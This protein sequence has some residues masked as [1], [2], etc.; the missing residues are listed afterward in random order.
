MKIN[1]N[2]IK[3]LLVSWVIFLTLTTACL[4]QYSGGSGTNAAPYEIA[5][6]LDL[7]NLGNTTADYDKHFI[8]IANVNMAGY[9]FSRAVIAADNS[10]DK[11]FLG[12]QFSGIFDGNGYTISNLT[13][14]ATDKDYIGLFGNVINA[15]IFNLGMEAVN[16]NNAGFGRY[17]G[18]LVGYSDHSTISNSF[19]TGIVGGNGYSIGGLVGYIDNGIIN[20]CYATGAVSGS[21]FYVGGL[22][23]YIDYGTVNNSYATAN[24]TSNGSSNGGLVGFN[25][26]GNISTSYASG[27]VNGGGWDVGGL[28]GRNLYGTISMSYALGA[29]S[30]NFPVGGLVGESNGGI[31]IC[32][33]S[34]LVSGLDRV[35]GLVGWNNSGTITACFWDTQTSNRAIGVGDGSTTGVMGKTTGEM[36][37]QSTFI[38]AG[39]DFE[40]IWTID[41]GQYPRLFVQKYSGGNGVSIAP[42]RITTINDL[43][44]LGQRTVD[45]NKCFILT[46]DIDLS[47]YSFVK[48]VIAS[49]TPFSGNFNGNGHTIS[50]LTING[51]DKDGV[52]LFGC[53]ASNA[54]ICYLGLENVNVTGKNN[55]GGLV[56][57]ND[58]STIYASYAKGFVTGSVDHVGGL[59]GSNS[60]GI[61]NDS[62]ASV[63][64]S[65]GGAAA[66]GLAGYNNSGVISNSYATGNVTGNVF[67]AGLVGYN[68]S[69]TITD[70][71]WD[72]QTSG[73]AIGIAGGIKLG[74]IG[75]S[76]N[77]MKKQ[78]TFTEAGWDFVGEQENG[79][80][81]IWYLPW[82]SYPIFALN[83]EVV[84]KSQ[85]G[86]Q[87]YL[88]GTEQE[89]RW[90]TFGDIDTILIEYSTDNGDN[91][92]SI[93]PANIGNTGSYFW[94]VPYEI[95]DQCLIRV[96][97][98]DNPGVNDA[99]DAVFSISP[100]TA[101]LI[102]PNGNESFMTG[103]PVPVIWET[104]GIIENISIEY[105]TDNGTVWHAV[106]P[107]NSGNLGGYQ[108]FAADTVSDEC[109]IRVSDA[110][111]PGV[112]D[113]SDNVFHIV[114]SQPQ[115][116]TLNG[117]EKLISGTIKK[118]KWWTRGS[119][120]EIA[121]EYSI[122][123]GATW[124]EMSPA[125]VGNT[126]SYEWNVPA[127][128][129]DECLVR[130]SDR[131]QPSRYDISDTIFEIAPILLQSNPGGQR[132][133]I[134][135]QYAIKWQA[136]TGII[137]GDVELAYSIDKGNNWIDIITTENNGEYLWNVPAT[138]SNGYLIQVAD[139]ANPDVNDISNVFVVYDCTKT[140]IGD[141][142][143]DCFVDLQDFILMANNWLM[144]GQL[145]L[146]E[147]DL[148]ND[149]QWSM[150]GQWQFGQPQGA[151]GTV[152]GNPDPTAGFTGTN[153]YG[154]NL[155]GDYD[156]AIAD[157]YY[158]T[159]GPIDCSLY[160]NIQLRFRSWLNSDTANYVGHTVEVS[161]DGSQ[162]HQ[163][164]INSEEA[165]TD[166]QWQEMEF[167]IS[168]YA[169]DNA[170]LYIRW[171]YQI[172]DRAYPYAGW[173]I[174]DVQLLGNP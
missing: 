131:Y 33:A 49:D 130:V 114:N 132:M 25:N 14:S 5:T 41:P 129:S 118:I 65:G 113:V 140:L 54:V 12:T 64:V 23:G 48:P 105:S 86:G 70:C 160:Y 80:D 32:Y 134:D 53:T 169:D 27:T 112:Y 174:D 55:V 44:I 135:S 120:S 69:G 110:D 15:S 10:T 165:I 92:S 75:K 17:V 106:D 58:N 166:E 93:S 50:N 9:S 172:I 46:S 78:V 87:F 7:I 102:H 38:T 99:S 144:A 96:S 167:D 13:I 39:W 45:Y 68:F 123:N 127:V 108:W 117:N 56:G 2:S 77:E 124:F 20:D 31:S 145:N 67:V 1:S 63:A 137:T 152:Y 111:H 139:A 28:V 95:S 37:I 76:T 81:D 149:P 97:D 16:I 171:G 91:W 115:L 141:I 19:S 159:A 161:A 119:I 156:T 71:F 11:Y 42:Y 26:Y 162:W 84:L 168:E 104:N 128:D 164:W 155:A 59:V 21:G 3:Y 60:Y 79:A 133:L 22:V 158:L 148:D 101:V 34:G 66:G 85:N 170:M 57:G 126:G 107:E 94:Q 146:I 30:G 83:I 116:L 74:A 40:Y 147:F 173:N 157:P 163:L 154:V 24:I 82:E 143:G 122:N 51:N 151:G 136:D 18:G 100:S 47:G 6:A 52:G 142:N 29:V 153:V 43:I 89:I 125:N 4:G 109:L 90:E 138:S 36:Q 103:I 8:L 88:S 61:I 62:Y 121:V 73:T 35:G 72:T 98:A 150:G